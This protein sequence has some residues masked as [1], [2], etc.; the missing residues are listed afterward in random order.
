MKIIY[1]LIATVLLASCTDMREI[2]EK[3]AG[4]VIELVKQNNEDIDA[5]VLGLDSLEKVYHEDK[6]ERD[7][8]IGFEDAIGQLENTNFR[9]VIDM[10]R[11]ETELNGNLPI[12][13]SPGD[14][15]L[16]TIRKGMLVPDFVI[17]FVV[18]KDGDRWQEYED[19]EGTMT[20]V[21]TNE[22]SHN[23][24]FG[25]HDIKTIANLSDQNELHLSVPYEDII[26]SF[27]DTPFDDLISAFKRLKE[28]YAVKINLSGKNSKK[29]TTS[30][31]QNKK[32]NKDEAEKEINDFDFDEA[33]KEYDDFITKYIDMMK[34]MKSGDMTA[35]EEYPE[36]L[37][38]ATTATDKLNKL[39][40]NMTAAQVNKFLKLQMKYLE[41]L[42]GM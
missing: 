20:L 38:K 6:T 12:I 41:T 25:Y 15:H 31:S 30:Y 3:A 35:L 28:V 10:N 22:I 2:G 21:G 34:K 14:G 8:E 33:L 11:Y 40:G 4:D 27:S 23:Y 26:G 24:A 37:E 39:K 19:Y 7:F 29:Q 9:H 36:M 16:I 5:I 42:Q 18:Y 32:E 1:L 13:Y 17:N